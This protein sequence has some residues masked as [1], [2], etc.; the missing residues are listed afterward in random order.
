MVA[1]HELMCVL[2]AGLLSVL[3]CLS[4]GAARAE[5]LLGTGRLEYLDTGGSCSAAL[6]RPDLVITAAHCANRPG[7]AANMRFRLGGFESEAT[8]GVQQLIPHPLYDQK[9]PRIEWR[10]RFD[11][12]VVQLEQAVPESL[13]TPLVQGDA[14]QVGETLYIVSWRGGERPRQRACP[15]I[16]GVPGLVTL[17]CQVRGGESGAPVLR[18]TDKGLEL[19]AVISSRSKLLEQPVA[20]ASNVLLRLPPLLNMIDAGNP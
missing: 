2:R 4:P 9:S 5:N 14:A 3:L 8:F 18:K 6:V 15:V 1:L 13:A 20:Q 12:A 17:G 11:I 7:R 16:E 19:V 10:L